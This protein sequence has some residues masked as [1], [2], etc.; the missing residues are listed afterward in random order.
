MSSIMIASGG[1]VEIHCLKCV[2][3]KLRRENRDVEQRYSFLTPHGEYVW[4]V[5]K[6]LRLVTANMAERAERG[7]FVT[8]DAEMM[9]TWLTNLQ[10]D[11]VDVEHARH[12]NPREPGIVTQAWDC[13][14]GGVAAVLID[15]T[16]RMFSAFVRGMPFH[17]FV[18]AH[19]ESMS[20]LIRRPYLS[21]EILS[22]MASMEAFPAPVEA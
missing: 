14:S 12:V 17:A 9:E 16:H 3:N 15:G 19:D 4:D 1:T 22:R 11:A 20:C 13:K 18:L 7:E 5:E 8:F 21:P 6:A 2:A 10:P